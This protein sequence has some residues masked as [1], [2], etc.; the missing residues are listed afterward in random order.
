M[1]LGESERQ[2]SSDTG[3]RCIHALLIE[4]VGSLSLSRLSDDFDDV[5]YLLTYGPAA[6]SL[7]PLHL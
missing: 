1:P 4:L 5:V 2:L 3:F 6:T 7:D